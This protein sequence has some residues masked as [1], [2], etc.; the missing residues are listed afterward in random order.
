LKSV[1]ISAGDA[2][3]ELHAAAL[4]EELRRR[5]PGLRLFGLGG[6]AMEKAGVELIVPQ[7]ALA[8][9]GLVEVLVDL[10]RIVSAW[11]RMTRA[12]VESRPDLVILVD[13]PDFNLPFA[14]RAKRLGIPVLYYVSPQVWAWRRG[15]IRKIARR[16][17]RLAV[18]FPFEP[19][20]YAGTGLA[21]DFVGHPLLDRLAPLAAGVDRAAARRALGLDA[22]RPLV[23]LLPG[24]RRNEVKRTLPLQLAAAT[25]LH[26]RDPRVG[27]AIAVAPSIA[28]A[29]ID[30]ALAAVRLPALLDLS[31]LEGRTHEAIRAAD[32]ALAK[33]GTVTLEIALLGTPQVVT[34]RVNALSAWLIRRLVRV[35][36]Y[37][38]PNLI[39]GQAVVPEFLQED[40][41]PERI[42]EAL[43]GLLA[44]P[45]REAQLAALATLRDALGGGGAAARA[46]R[47]AEEMTRGSAPS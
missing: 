24:S 41:D 39:A 8:V 36:S 9:G 35:S 38:M 11:R 29:A 16:V 23:L 28:R 42:A 21:V 31:V 15:R 19:E 5:A 33:P 20:V 26:A 47:I 22:E 27:F 25:A 1:L 2:S 13:S 6:P 43:R 3:G 45:A 44:G 18:I 14:R 30:E 46:A 32:V 7:H 17:D 37:T 12:L 34:T 4:A 10:P 40:A